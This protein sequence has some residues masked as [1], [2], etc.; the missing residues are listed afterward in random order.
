MVTG[1]STYAVPLN[2]KQSDAKSPGDTARER[3]NFTEVF[4]KEAVQCG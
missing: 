3:E 1:W 4:V 2:V